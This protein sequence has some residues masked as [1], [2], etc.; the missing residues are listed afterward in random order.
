MLYSVGWFSQSFMAPPAQDVIFKK[1]RFCTCF[2]MRT[3]FPS[4]FSSKIW[5]I[6]MV[7]PCKKLIAP[8]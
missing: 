8:N 5:D 4:H 6:W 2:G 7:S 3:T 1:I